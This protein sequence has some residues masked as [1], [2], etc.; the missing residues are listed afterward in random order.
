MRSPSAEPVAFALWSWYNLVGSLC[1][2]T[3]YTKKRYSVDKPFI[4]KDIREFWDR[5]HITLS[6]WFRDYV[7]SRITMRFVR[8]KWFKSKIT[9]SSVG[10]IINMTIMGIWHG[11]SLHYSV[12]RIPAERS[13]E[14]RV[15]KECRSRWSP[16]H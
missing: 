11:L 9:T 12:W 2:Y 1:S 13:E 7:F 15:G 8:N 10:F 5:W 14:R 4:S 16:Y 3:N 6:Y